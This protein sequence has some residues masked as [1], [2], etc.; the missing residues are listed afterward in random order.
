M[1]QLASVGRSTSTGT[2]SLGGRLPSLTGLRWVAAFLVFGMHVRNFGFFGPGPAANVMATVFQAGGTGVSFFFILS[3]FVLMWSSRPKDTALGFLRRRVARI[4]PVHLVCVA[5]A[6]VL[7][8][9]IGS[10]MVPTAGQLVTNVLLLHSWSPDYAYYQSLDPVSWSL[11]CELL[12]YVSFPLFGRLARHLQARGAV[13]FAAVSA[14]AVIAVPIAVTVHPISW[15]IYFFPLARLGEFTLGIALARLVMLGRWHGPGLDVALG[16]TLIG[17]F[18]V[19]AL[20]G[21]FGN[22]FCTLL[23]FSLLI[24][25][26]ATADLRGTHSVWRQPVMERLGEWSFS[27]YMVHVMVLSAVKTLLPGTISLSAPAGLVVVLAMFGVSLGLS[28][29]LFTFVETPGRKLIAG[30]R[31]KKRVTTAPSPA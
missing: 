9:T 4:Y 1:T 2:A 30:G 20:P 10:E 31:R 22:T 5:I 19:P 15:P 23:G 16:V 11:V 28:W 14:L 21:A 13:V 3:G 25:A 8:L 24:P 12:F 6:L 29:A 18:V 7:A 26:A 17:Y 27:F